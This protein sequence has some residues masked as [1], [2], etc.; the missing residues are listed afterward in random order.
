M[1]TV[2]DGCLA[3]TYVWRSWSIDQL[4]N[5]R[6]FYTL[7][8]L[9]PKQ[10]GMNQSKASGPLKHRFTDMGNNQNHNKVPE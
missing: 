9:K 7:N 6:R 8:G 1:S 10:H 4:I 3:L 5:L 2:E